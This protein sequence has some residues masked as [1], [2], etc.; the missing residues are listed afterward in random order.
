MQTVSIS[1]RA[2]LQRINQALAS[3]HQVLKATRG[4]SDRL[5]FGDYY[6]VDIASHRVTKKKV[7]P[8][9]LGRELG[10]LR[11]YEQLMD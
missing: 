7:D 5:E 1:R 11:E 3:D 10:V 9:K 8:V 4:E 6:I 2:L